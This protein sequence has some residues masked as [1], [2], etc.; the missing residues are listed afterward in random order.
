MSKVKGGID[1]TPRLTT[2]ANGETKKQSN[3]LNPTTKTSQK[4][5]SNLNNNQQQAYQTGNSGTYPG[6]QRNSTTHQGN[7]QFQYRGNNSTSVPSSN[8][9]QQFSQTANSAFSQWNQQQKT[10]NN[11]QQPQQ[12]QISLGQTSQQP[13][14]N[15]YQQQNTI[16]N[17]NTLEYE[18]QN[19]QSI[20]TGSSQTTV[21]TNNSQLGKSDLFIQN[22]RVSNTYRPIS[23]QNNINA[24]QEKV[25]DNSHLKKQPNQLK[26]KLNKS[27]KSET[28]LKPGP[29]DQSINQQVQQQQSQQQSVQQINTY[30]S[31]YNQYQN[32]LISATALSTKANQ[33]NVNI[34]SI[35]Q[36]IGNDTSSTPQ[37]NYI[38]NSNQQS[39]QQIQQQIITPE[40]Q[41]NANLMNQQQ[42]LSNLN[43]GN[44]MSNNSNIYSKYSGQLRYDSA[45]LRY[46]TAH[47]QHNQNNPQFGMQYSQRFL[48]P[49]TEPSE[50]LTNLTSQNLYQNSSAAN[51]YKPRSPYKYNFKDKDASVQNT[52]NLNPVQTGPIGPKFGATQYNAMSYTQNSENIQSNNI[53]T[54]LNTVN[55][56]SNSSNPSSQNQF[57]QNK[58]PPRNSQRT[59]AIKQNQPHSNNLNDLG[60]VRKS[61]TPKK[62]YPQG[63]SNIAEFSNNTNSDINITQNTSKQ[64]NFDTDG[65]SRVS[66]VRKNAQPQKDLS[67]MFLIRDQ[68]TGQVYDIR[69]IDKIDTFQKTN[70][71]EYFDKL[72]KR[73]K[74]AWQGWWNSKKE[75]NIKMIQSVRQNSFSIIEQLLQHER[76][77]LR[78]DTDFKDQNQWSSIHYAAYNGNASI[79]NLLISHDADVNITN[80]LEQTAL[81]IAAEKG[82]DEIVDICIKAGAEINRQDLN[83]N[84]ALH[85]ACKN[86]S[87]QCVRLLLQCKNIDV[88]L[89]NVENKLAIECTKNN[90]I[91]NVFIELQ[92][93]NGYVTQMQ[94]NSSNNNNS[95]TN[96][97]NQSNTNNENNEYNSQ[98]GKK[99]HIVN[100]LSEDT[101][102]QNQIISNASI[103][104]SN[105]N[106]TPN[107]FSQNKGTH[108]QQRGTTTYEQ[109]LSQSALSGFYSQKLTLSSN[110]GQANMNNS[111]KGGGDKQ[112]QGGLHHSNSVQSNPQE[113]QVNQQT[114][115]QKR[116]FEVT[117]QY[118]NS[119]VMSS[120]TNNN[121][122]NSNSNSKSGGTMYGLESSPN[123]AYTQS[124]SSQ[125]SSLSSQNQLTDSQINNNGSNLYGQQSNQ[126]PWRVIIH[127]F[128]NESVMKMFS[129]S[130]RKDK[131]S[132]TSSGNYNNN[133][134]GQISTTNNANNNVNTNVSTNET[135]TNSGQY[136]NN[137]YINPE[138]TLSPTQKHHKIQSQDSSQLN[139]SNQ[140]QQQLSQQQQ[141]QQQQQNQQLNQAQDLNQ[142][143]SQKVGPQDFRIVNQIGRGSFGEVYLV[144]KKGQDQYFAMKMLHK[145][146][147]L[148]QNLTKYAMTERNVLSIMSHPFIVKLMYAF[149]TSKDLFLIMEYMPG[150]DLSHALQRDKRFSE[151]RARI[152]LSEIM[153]AI[154][155]LHKHDIIYRDLKPENIVIDGEGHAMLTDFG[156]SKDGVYDHYSTHSFCGSLAYLAPEMLKRCGHGKAVDYYHLG[157]LLYE[158]LTGSP[159]FFSDSK[160]EICHNI[161]FQE[162]RFPS[163][164]SDNARNLISRLLVKNP[165][166]RLGFGKN[167][168]E[169]IKKHPFFNGFNWTHAIQRKLKPPPPYIKPIV[170]SKNSGTPNFMMTMTPLGMTTDNHVNGWSF[171]NNF[172]NNGLNNNQNSN[173]NNNIQ[174]IHNHHYSSGNSRITNKF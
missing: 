55:N 112:A 138:Q 16:E 120:S 85:F 64:N 153:L 3:G 94:M 100:H 134:V 5:S 40:I 75:N 130:P 48:S 160:D 57:N 164:V 132:N 108:Y 53:N 6:V 88:N 96:N 121:N 107:Q 173:N 56:D 171:I 118:S 170:D 28:P 7:Y 79:L 114:D 22:Y 72:K 167:D 110:Y 8:V 142:M 2:G 19:I 74:N 103:S 151:Q 11:A 24:N 50:F 78:A 117:K 67:E 133:Q 109:I 76:A 124:I 60:L 131:S 141:M 25:Q 143:Q 157:V 129:N 89:K 14:Q 4:Y 15:K 18:D 13:V 58:S 1:Y 80:N 9:E 105:F 45:A 116:S 39:T 154:K 83:Q 10:Q 61:Q 77:D 125:E 84:T 128:P 12:Q 155:H 146:K 101:T 46:G 172:E 59:L 51:S 68:D 156:L 30:Q 70:N 87:A 69:Q 119:G 113:K 31:Q 26:V 62:T 137:Q 63:S 149:Q 174:I 123:K 145:S 152:Y 52:V 102:A 106:T 35:P 17:Q 166:K 92:K 150:G 44:I 165:Q 95:S 20:Q 41:T 65:N 97:N 73:H 36:N 49:K 98:K 162:I 81:M 139:K 33:N 163:Y 29:K 135:I 136:N 144:E 161:E 147:V 86:N 140:Q 21:L 158:M 54:K 82:F 91:I 90:D 66:P 127:D 42:Q 43:Q 71:Q 169:E 38:Q 47:S 104:N 99:R 34:P 159:P 37:G 126:Q 148:G 27:S 23:S 115:N 168:F 111:N 32:G 122:R 93:D